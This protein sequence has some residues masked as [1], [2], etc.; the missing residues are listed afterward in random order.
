MLNTV[1]VIEAE[2]NDTDIRMVDGQTPDDGRVEVCI[3][4]A[5]G[6]ICDDYWDT[7]DATVACRQLGYD[8]RKVPNY[9][10]CSVNYSY[11]TVSY[12]LLRYGNNN[13]LVMHLDDVYCDGS[14]IKLTECDHRGFGVHNC[15]KGRDGAGV[16][17]TSTSLCLCTTSLDEL[18]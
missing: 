11:V 16:I 18:H 1:L 7:R 15:L 9:P 8:G 17:C 14:E 10:S 6:S 12:P 3:N 13:P 5:W 2:C 4:G